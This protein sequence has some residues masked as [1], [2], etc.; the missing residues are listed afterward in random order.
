MW[1]SSTRSLVLGHRHGGLDWLPSPDWI[2][3][4]LWKKTQYYNL[5]YG[6]KACFL[7]VIYSLSG[8]MSSFAG[9]LTVNE[10]V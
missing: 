4:V 8:M 7:W 9:C 2:S 6:S 3:G 5:L 1:Q 10:F